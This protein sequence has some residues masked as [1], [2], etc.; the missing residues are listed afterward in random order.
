MCAENS[1]LIALHPLYLLAFIFET[2]YARW[3]HWFASLWMRVN[4][5]ETAT[6]MTSVSWALRD[7]S[8]SRIKALKDPDTLLTFL[9][10]THT[11]MCH[12]ENIASFANKFGPFCLDV[13]NVLEQARMDQGLPG[14]SSRYTFGLEDRIKYTATRCDFVRDRMAEMKERLRGQINVVGLDFPG[15]SAMNTE[16]TSLQSFSLIAQK[17]SKVAIQ[18]SGTMKAIATLGLIFLPATLTTVL[19]NTLLA[20][21]EIR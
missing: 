8:P 5:I 20:L 17:D 13:L 2:R 1:E 21:L 9:H 10:G 16:L 14:L 12:S 19:T 18:D 3:T 6:N 15:R 7:A 11:E 4:E